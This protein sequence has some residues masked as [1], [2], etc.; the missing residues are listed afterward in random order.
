MQDYDESVYGYNKKT[1]IE[2]AVDKN[3]SSIVYYFAK[4]H[5]QHIST[6]D[7]VTNY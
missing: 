2:R 6:L 3:Y 5:N 1:P 7:Q 4:E